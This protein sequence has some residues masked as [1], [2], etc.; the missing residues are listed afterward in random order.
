M[1]PWVKGHS[2]GHHCPTL[3]LF[4][5]PGGHLHTIP[6]QPDGFLSS[7]ASKYSLNAVVSLLRQHKARWTRKFMSLKWPSINKG[8]ELV[9]RSSSSISSQWYNHEVCVIVSQMVPSGFGTKLSTELTCSST[10]PSLASPA[11]LSCFS[12]NHMPIYLLFLSLSAFRKLQIKTK[13]MNMLKG[14]CFKINTIKLLSRRIKSACT[15][16]KWA[17]LSF[18]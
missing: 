3:V 13:W 15:P 2:R 18:F 10:H 17:L 7:S 16:T 11:S 12:W 1:I 6:I 9:D 8:W 14:L 5:Y 4:A